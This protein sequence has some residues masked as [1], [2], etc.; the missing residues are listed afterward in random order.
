[1]NQLD[2][3][4][5]IDGEWTLLGDRVSSAESSE[6]SQ[7]LDEPQIIDHKLD[8]A[9]ILKEVNALKGI[10][11]NQ[12]KK[13]VALQEQKANCS[14]ADTNELVPSP[15]PVPVYKDVTHIPSA[16]LC[17]IMSIYFE[18]V[19]CQN[20][21]AFRDLVNYASISTQKELFL[22]CLVKNK[23]YLQHVCNN[24]DAACA[25]VVKYAQY[26]LSI[27]IFYSK[28]D[29]T[30]LP[31]MQKSSDA[32]YAPAMNFVAVHRKFKNPKKAFELKMAAALQRFAIA[33][34][35]VGND[36]LLG[37][38]VE[39]DE[40]QAIRWYELAADQ[41]YASAQFELADCYMQGKGDGSWFQ[42]LAFL[43][44]AAWK[45]HEKA[46]KEVYRY[47][48]SLGILLL[49][50]LSLIVLVYDFCFHQKQMQVAITSSDFCKAPV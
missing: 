19:R 36:Y 21:A 32:G 46:R 10:I 33:Q 34:Y 4:Q 23:S 11:E 3:A 27:T 41:G 49:V 12:E 28:R 40:K 29:Y 30:W 45:G 37:Q 39:K 18:Q 7:S 26:L 50:V 31:L 15:A 24:E 22:T 20:N 13:I 47:C 8:L 43:T 5:N 35:N 14:T 42:G 16:N 2:D 6:L 38:G 44:L 48:C 17:A 9:C 25:H 1:M